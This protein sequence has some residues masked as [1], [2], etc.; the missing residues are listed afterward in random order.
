MDDG[1]GEPEALSD[2]DKSKKSGEECSGIV[3]F[4]GVEGTTI[5]SSEMDSWAWGSEKSLHPRR[6]RKNGFLK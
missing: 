5:V 2:D 3:V 6:K 4:E 1:G